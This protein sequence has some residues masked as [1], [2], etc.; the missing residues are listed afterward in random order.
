MIDVKQIASRLRRGEYEVSEL[1]RTQPQVYVKFCKICDD[2]ECNKCWL[3]RECP[4]RL[5]IESIDETYIRLFGYKTEI[6]EE[7]VMSLLQ[8]ED[9][10]D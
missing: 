1:R 4:K 8:K 10:H 2:S 3:D 7:D 6:N 5:T 9:R